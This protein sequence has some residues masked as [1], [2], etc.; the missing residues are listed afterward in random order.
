[1]G[2]LGD[3]SVSRVW[4]ALEKAHLADLIRSKPNGLNENVGEMGGL[5]SGGEM[6]RLVLARYI[7]LRA[8]ILILDEATSAL[9][10]K[11]RVAV[12]STLKE[13]AKNMTIIVVTH[14][15]ELMQA[16]DDVLTLTSL[17]L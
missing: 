12:I 11:S 17:K 16:S 2:D 7:Y 4:A 5:L 6:Q 14:D 9:D 10:L 15:S 3:I 13:L 1:M 8:S